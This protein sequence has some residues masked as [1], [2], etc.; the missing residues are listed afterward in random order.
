ML[1][2]TL[3]LSKCDNSMVL[4]GLV[5]NVVV[6]TIESVSND[7]IGDHSNAIEQYFPVLLFVYC[8]MWF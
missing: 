2:R 4:F 1:T 7:D 5:Q 6:I 8:T 3:P